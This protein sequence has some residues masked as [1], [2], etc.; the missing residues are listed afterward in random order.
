MTDRVVVVRAA[1]VT[2]VRENRIVQVAAPGIQGPPGETGPEGPQGPQGPEGPAGQYYVHT[3]A[4]PS[5]SWV[6]D[7]NLNKKVHVS[8]FNASGDLVYSDVHHGSLNQASIVFPA[9]FAG[10]AVLS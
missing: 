10:S 4:S 2:V 9:P 3:Q 5:A 8:I 6:I 1:P 7:H